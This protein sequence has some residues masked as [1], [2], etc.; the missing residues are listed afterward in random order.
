MYED[1]QDDGQR[2]RRGYVRKPKYC[3]FCVEKISEPDY[4]QVDVLRRYMTDQGRIRP[5]RQT[6]T[7]AR[8]QRMVTDVLKRSRAMALLPYVAERS[9]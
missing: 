2:G 9:R 5:R 1:S 7:C 4:K 8:H 6:G 3:Q